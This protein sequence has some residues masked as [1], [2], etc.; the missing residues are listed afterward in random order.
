MIMDNDFKKSILILIIAGLLIV[1]ILLFSFAIFYPNSGYNDSI[2]NTLTTGVFSFSFLEPSNG[3]LINNALPKTDIEGKTQMG[4]NET[5][6]FTLT[7]TTDGVHAIHYTVVALQD[8]ASTLPVEWVKIYLTKLVNDTE[9]EINSEPIL[10]MQLNN[11]NNNNY[12]KE[13]YKNS[14][15]SK[16]YRQKFRFRMWIKDGIN[17]N[18]PNYANKT[19]KVKINVYAV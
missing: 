3:I 7:A 5:F 14:I 18:D 6:D 10:F 17:V 9:I 16:D 1:S 13:V 2:D 15:V 4:K 8:K 12:A 19:F 11:Y